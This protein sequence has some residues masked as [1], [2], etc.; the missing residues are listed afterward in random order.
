MARLKGSEANGDAGTDAFSFV[1]MQKSPV[2][3]ITSILVFTYTE[4]LFSSRFSGHTQEKTG[5]S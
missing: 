4:C 2:Y 1:S 3:I 5:F